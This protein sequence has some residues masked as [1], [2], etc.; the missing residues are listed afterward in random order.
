[1]KHLFFSAAIYLFST[2]YIFG[3]VDTVFNQTDENGQKQGYWKK[4]YPNGNLIYKGF[5]KDNMPVGEMVRF[6]ESGKTQAR[7]FYREDGITT[8]TKLYYEDGELS[9]EGLYRN[10]QKDSIWKYYSFYSG[11]LVSEE[12]YAM[13]KK[14]GI[15]KNYYANGQLSE[16]VGYKNDIKE[17]I[18]KQYFED[19]KTKLSASY[20]WNSV[21]GRYTFCYPT[22]VIMMLGM[23]DEN[24]KNGP[25]IYYDE[26]GN[27]K[28]RIRY[29]MGVVHAEDEKLLIKQDEEFF[30]MIDENNGKFED[31]SIDDLFN[32][33]N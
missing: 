26:E 15:Q 18:W 6:Y 2:L 12:F 5:F 9:A 28:Y 10:M 25:W 7:L 30:K 8:M 19:G 24:K 33:P 11:T 23:Y 32:G 4:H 16:E 31:P 22:G 13:G 1:M 14:D 29:E 17:G 21:N 20:K 3:Q 27:E